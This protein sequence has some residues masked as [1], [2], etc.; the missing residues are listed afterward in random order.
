M[1][2]QSDKILIGWKEYCSLPDL[3]VKK[4]IAKVDTGADTSAL[5]ALNIKPFTDRG[6]PH[7]QFEVYPIRFNNMFMQVCTAPVVDYRVI[8]SS[9]GLHEKR[10]VISTRLILGEHEYLTQLTLTNRSFLN[11]RMLLGKEFLSGN[12]IIDTSQK[13]CQRQR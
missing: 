13:Y 8:R 12:V 11:Y 9:N 2:P 5:H 7:V 1:L 3:N 6:E 4:I 10:F